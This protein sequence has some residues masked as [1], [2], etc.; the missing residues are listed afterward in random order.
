VTLTLNR[1]NFHTVARQLFAQ[2][3][4]E[5]EAKG[6]TAKDEDLEALRTRVREA[7]EI[8]GGRWS[9]WGDRAVDT[10]EALEAIAWPATPDTRRTGA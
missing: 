8:A 7:I 5:G 4:S 10:V 9:E 6:L 3:I 2:A 1:E